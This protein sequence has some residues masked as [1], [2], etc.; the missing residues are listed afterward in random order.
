MSK[1]L[2]VAWLDLELGKVS[3]QYSTEPTNQV[4]QQVGDFKSLE[5]HLKRNGSD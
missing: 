2:S 1:V 4:V 3:I 5:D